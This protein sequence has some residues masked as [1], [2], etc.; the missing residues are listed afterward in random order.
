MS[1]SVMIMTLNEEANLPGALRSLSWC[2]DVVV[3]DSYSSD[4]TAEVAEEFGARVVKRKFD[5]FGPHQT[6]GLKNIEYKHRWVFMLDAD[7]RMTDSLREELESVAAKWESG[8][9]NEQDHPVAYY[10]GRRNFFM[11]KWIKHSMGPGN[12]MR[13]FQ[14]PLIRFERE[15]HQIPIVDGSIGYLDG[16]FDHY[17]FSKGIGEWFDRHNR[18]ATMES[19]ETIRALKENPV[20]FGNLFSKDR[21][22]RRLEMKNISF[23]LPFR[24]YFKFVY[25]Y[26]L[27][28]GFLDGRAGLT[29]C[30]IQSIY[31]YIIVLKV[32][33]IRRGGEHADG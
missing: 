33:E 10:C 31:E 28:F 6:W 20:R 25:M 3:F 14:P 22:T 2:D 32:R 26:L 11:G 24:P 18:Y 7:E 4:K 23:R 8:E 9:H 5:S 12:N 30:T 21:N 15:V 13:F 19:H 16:M 1:V 17:N 29:Y 27:K